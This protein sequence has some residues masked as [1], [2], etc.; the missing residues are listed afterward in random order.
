MEETRENLSVQKL[1]MSVSHAYFV[2]L[3]HQLKE[4]GVHPGQV[5]LLFLL[6]REDRLSQK[7]IV[8]RLGLSAPTVTMS[9]RRLEKGEFVTRRQDENDQ[10]VS[11]ICLSGKGRDCTARMQEIF[12]DNEKKLTRGFRETELCLFHRFCEQ[13]KE[14]IQTLEGGNRER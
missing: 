9:I 13:L 3:Y 1:L 5:P 4:L 12:D 8:E 14:N 10:R 6:E 2:S 11:R 7:E